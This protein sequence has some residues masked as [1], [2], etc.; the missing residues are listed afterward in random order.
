MPKDLS[1]FST[2]DLQKL[3]DMLDSVPNNICPSDCG[4]HLYCSECPMRQSCDAIQQD[5][6]DLYEEIKRR[7]QGDK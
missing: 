5:Y 6:S 4:I 1:K 3:V 2:H 7:S